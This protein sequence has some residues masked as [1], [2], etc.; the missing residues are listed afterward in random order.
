MKKMT[1]KSNTLHVLDCF[2]QE[3]PI[4]IEIECIKKILPL[5]SLEPVPNSPYYL[6]G[7]ANFAGVVIPIVDL[8]MRLGIARSEEY[9]VDMSILLCGYGEYQAGFLVDKVIRISEMDKTTIQLHSD[10]DNNATYFNG[11]TTTKNNVSLLVNMRQ[12]LPVHI[13]NDMT[14]LPAN[15]GGDDAKNRS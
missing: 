1:D 15:I 5:L 13:Y 6:I 14:P 7:L 8:A 2:V 11:T 4:C 10:F 3:V 9:T 12:L